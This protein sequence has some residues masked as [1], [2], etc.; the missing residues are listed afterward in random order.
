MVDLS[1][2]ATPIINICHLEVCCVVPGLELLLDGIM[3]PRLQR[4]RGLVLPIFLGLV[5]RANPIKTLDTIHHLII[6]DQIDNEEKCFSFKQWH[7]ILD[8]LPCLRTLLI[9]FN[10]AKCPPLEMA[11]L[12]INYIKRTTR[13]P[14]TL[15]SCCID[16][17]SEQDSK[18]HFL[19]YLVDR[20]E[21]NCF[22]VQFSSVGPT[23]YDM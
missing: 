18:E 10:N 12:L 11:N 1:L 6:L 17:C 22:D 14:L 4:L 21:A 16:D 15:F 2:T 3:L 20:V 19:N 13:S 9:Q 23:R 5:R 8:V 7:T